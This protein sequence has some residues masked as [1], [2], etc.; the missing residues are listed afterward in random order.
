MAALRLRLGSMRS[1]PH[2][3]Y[4]GQFV[5]FQYCWVSKPRLKDKNSRRRVLHDVRAY[6]RQM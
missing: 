3:A 1:A 4:A 5:V 6:A 2:D